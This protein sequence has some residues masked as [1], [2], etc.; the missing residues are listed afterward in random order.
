[1]DTIESGEN[2]TSTFNFNCSPYR[3][4]MFRMCEGINVIDK[5]ITETYSMCVNIKV[6]DVKLKL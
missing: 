4:A 6:M 1:L 3:R 5:D 2:R